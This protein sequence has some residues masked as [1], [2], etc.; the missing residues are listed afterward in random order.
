MTPALPH[1][2]NLCPCFHALFRKCFDDIP[3]LEIGEIFEDNTALVAGGNFAYIVFAPA[4]RCDLA[5]VDYA[6]G[7]STQDACL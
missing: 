2:C 5:I 3:D 1:P 6:G 4:Q 7:I